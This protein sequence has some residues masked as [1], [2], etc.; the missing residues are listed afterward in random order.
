MVD[1]RADGF[2]VTELQR[3]GAGGRKIWL[4]MQRWLLY[5]LNQNPDCF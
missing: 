4:A 2:E 1:R 3:G 5:F